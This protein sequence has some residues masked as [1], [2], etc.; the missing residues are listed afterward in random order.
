MTSYTLHVLRFGHQLV[1]AGQQQTLFLS[2]QTIAQKSTISLVV[3][4]IQASHLTNT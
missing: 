3:I 4:I 2:C 1:T